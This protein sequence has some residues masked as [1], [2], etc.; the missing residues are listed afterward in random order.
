MVGRSD[1]GAGSMRIAISAQEAAG[2]AA[3]RLA[4]ASDHTVVAVLTGNDSGEGAERGVTVE[5]VA[6]ELGLLVHPARLVKDPA[7]GEEMRRLRVDVLL[8]VHSLYLVAA[9]VLAVPTLGSFNLHPGPLPTYAGLNVP[10]WA[11][12]QGERRHAVTLHWMAARVDAGAVAYEAWFDIAPRDTGLSVSARCVERGVPLIGKL[13]DCMAADPADVPAREQDLAGRRWYGR[14]V[15]H[16]GWLP[17]SLPARRIVD[18]VRACD[19]GPWPS[20]WGRPRTLV[21]GAEVQILRATET[22]ESTDRPP[23]TVGAAEGG[24]VLVAA[25]DEWVSVARVRTAGAAATPAA[26]LLQEG[27]PLRPVHTADRV[28]LADR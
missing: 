3:L 24:A 5:S 13:L 2:I 22:G 16:G 27:D 23:G 28:N 7:F 20:P 19:Y 4:A 12:Y 18:F 6:R 8:N 14:E 15:P 26:A 25:A 17:W 11:V 1:V 9:E 21:E 10:S